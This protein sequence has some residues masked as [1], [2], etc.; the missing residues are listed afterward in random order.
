MSW[1]LNVLATKLTQV[2]TTSYCVIYSGSVF[3]N[4]QMNHSSK[5]GKNLL[6][7][8]IYS[9]YPGKFCLPYRQAIILALSKVVFF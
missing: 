8:E 7:K 9:L 2:K 5:K 3:L 6:L 1:F 4:M